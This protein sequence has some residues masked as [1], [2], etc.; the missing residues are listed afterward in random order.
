MGYTT[1][2]R[3]KFTIDPPLTNDEAEELNGFCSIRHEGASDV[4]ITIWCDWQFTT[5]TMSWN[6]T[7]KSYA[8]DE[9]AKWLL[10]NKLQ[11][12]NLTGVVEAQGEEFGDRWEMEAQGRT[13][14]V[15]R[16]KSRAT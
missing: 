4:G 10:Q 15:R 7:E 5:T 14:L 2:F 16:L 8:M 11:G 9:W 6:G 1:E 13:I 3:G 12:H